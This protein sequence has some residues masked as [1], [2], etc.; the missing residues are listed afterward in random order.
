MKIIVRSLV[1][2]G[3]SLV[4]CLLSWMPGNGSAR[5]A[6]KVYK[7]SFAHHMSTSS[8][9]HTKVYVRLKE[10]LE[11]LSNGRI[12]VTLYPGGALGKPQA[13]YDMVT[14]GT[15]DM[16]QF[17]PDYTPGVFPLS[18]VF[19]LPF[20]IPN[21][22]IGRK[23]VGE[24]FEKK[25]LDKKFYNG[26]S[27]AWIGTTSSYQLFLGKKRVA[28][29]EDLRGLKIRT[30][31][32]LLSDSL[33]ALGATPVSVPGGEFPTA[34]ERG[35]VDGGLISFAGARSYRLKDLC[36]YATKVDV[37]VIVMGFMMNRAVY[38]G[39]PKDLQQVVDQAGKKFLINQVESFDGTDQEV[40]DEVKKAGV[41][42]VELSP[43]EK[44]RWVQKCVP[45]YDKWI[46][47]MKKK[48]LPVEQE[49]AEYKTILKKYGVELPR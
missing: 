15:A 25:L 18:D 12:Q 7:L 36:K 21:A 43:A 11:K 46:S 44:A 48:G 30:P 34:L 3:V 38:E 29:M 41:E 27:I 37:G 33:T 17:L 31:G 14:K 10:D 16:V 8:P 26:K 24:M 2:L 28:T 1:I 19:C 6:D 5:A 20:A 13:E 32:G 23:V 45:I 49:Y 35:V 4:V 47:E 39:L 22:E 42:I 9:L 40:I